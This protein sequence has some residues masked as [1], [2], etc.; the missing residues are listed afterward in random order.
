MK[1]KLKVTN[2]RLDIRPEIYLTKWF[3][4]GLLSSLVSKDTDEL[5]PVKFLW[6]IIFLNW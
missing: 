1:K 2:Q 6:H 3:K 5:F 4:D